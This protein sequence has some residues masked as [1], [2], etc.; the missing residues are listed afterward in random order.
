[1]LGKGGISVLQTSIFVILIIKFKW[2]VYAMLQIAEL[3]VN[4]L[5]RQNVLY[6]RNVASLSKFLILKARDAFRQNPPQQ[7]PVS[8]LWCEYKC[9]KWSE[10]VTL[11]VEII[12]VYLLLNVGVL[13]KLLWSKIEKVPGDMGVEK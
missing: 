11:C 4:R 9:Y 2:T 1:M 3:V 7:L 12:S 10:T 13:F 8:H 6:A 5:K